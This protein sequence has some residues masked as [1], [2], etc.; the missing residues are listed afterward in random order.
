MVYNSVMLA[1]ER[2]NHED[3]E[4]MEGADYMTRIF[5]KIIRKEKKEGDRMDKGSWKQKIRVLI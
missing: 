1:I 4:F 5:S 2:R 3:C